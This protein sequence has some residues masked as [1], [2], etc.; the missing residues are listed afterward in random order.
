LTAVL[1]SLGEAGVLAPGEPGAARLATGVS[2]D[3]LV[4]EAERARERRAE[5]ERSRVDMM[6]RY[7]ELKD[8]RRQFMLAYFGEELARPCG[9]CDNCVAGAADAA[10]KHAHGVLPAQTRIVHQAFGSGTV[11][12]EEG[13]RVVVLFDEVGYKTLDLTVAL[14]EGLVT[15][16]RG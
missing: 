13:D 3:E 9:N 6:R 7:A 4:G 12:R 16:E 11:M 1:N 14:E 15:L 10:P 2:V 8:C 5:F